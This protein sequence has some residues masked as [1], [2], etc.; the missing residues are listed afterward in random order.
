MKT[1][2]FIIFFAVFF[3][4]YLGSSA[5]VIKHVMNLLKPY[6]I[7]YLVLALML[8]FS[9]GIILGRF[10][11]N[12]IPLELSAFFTRI[13]FVWMS[14][15]TYSFIYSLAFWLLRRFDL[16]RISESNGLK[17][18]IV[19]LFIYIGIFLIGYYIAVNPVI[20]R[21]EIKITKKFNSPLRIVQLSDLHLGFMYTESMFEKVIDKVEKINPDLVLISGDF[22][23]NENAYAEKK[24][25]GKSV[26]RLKP[27]YG[28]FFSPGNHEY[29]NDINKSLKYIQ[30]L[31]INILRDSTV[32][33]DKDIYLIGKD[34]ESAP[35]FGN[36]KLKPLD[37]LLP[38]THIDDNAN[39]PLIVLMTHQIKNHHD[40][41]DKG[42][43]LVISGHTHHGQ[44]FPWNL[45]VKLIFD[46]AYGYEKWGDT[47]FY[48]SSGTGFW[49]PP[50]RLG[51]RSEIVV[52]D[53]IS[54]SE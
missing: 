16:I 17:I 46:I 21:H 51:T 26:N 43:D 1:I 20:T 23:E 40:Y 41:V 34:D 27:K 39:L 13:G 36:F 42:L 15:L 8:L 52:F 22:L 14:L 48:V 10:F 53:L 47:N 33:I 31:N 35:R 18:F 7:K 19:E 49:G 44:F 38:R 50:F 25:I 4:V 11:A 12:Y 9:L 28:M 37:E 3:G 45:I 30:S 32:M 5:M 24:N 29:I 6:K 2:N 54:V